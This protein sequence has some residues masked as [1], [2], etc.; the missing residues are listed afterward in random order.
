MKRRPAPLLGF[1]SEETAMV[2]NDSDCGGE[3]KTSAF[4]GTLGSKKGLEDFFSQGAGN[5]MARIAYGNS[6]VTLRLCVG[7]ASR[8]RFVRIEI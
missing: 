5:S 3:P 8:K 4:V 6:H 7:L 2:P 1:E